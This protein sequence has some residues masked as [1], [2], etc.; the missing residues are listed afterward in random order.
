MRR[1]Y[2]MYSYLVVFS[3]SLLNMKTVLLCL[4]FIFNQFFYIYS[5]SIYQFGKS[6]I[7]YF[8]FVK[9]ISVA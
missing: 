7:V 9:K 8:P 2:M 1:Y 4:S 3:E 6:L 5:V